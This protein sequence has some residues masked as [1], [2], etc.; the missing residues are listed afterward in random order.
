MS[1]E[2]SHAEIEHRLERLR[3]RYPP[4]EF[5]EARHECDPEQWAG[6]DPEYVGGAYAWVVRRADEAPELTPS[7][8]DD[9]APD[10]D[11]V[12]MILGRGTNEWG[13]AGGGVED[14]ESYEQAAVR[15]VEEETGIEC[16]VGDPFAARRVRWVEAA[17][18]RERHSLH[19]FFDAR[20]EGGEIRV[21][22]GEL[23]GAAWFE[24]PPARMHPANEFRAESWFDGTD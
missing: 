11:R 8:P 1:P 2:E 13:L 21:Q 17:G 20:Y 4:F 19:V 16:S 10:G 5:E 14:D 18:D 6:L 15:E 23:N 7:M 3:E 24:E 22:G 12:L 9:A